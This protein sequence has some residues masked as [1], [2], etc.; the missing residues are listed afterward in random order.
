MLGLVV[1]H[2]VQSRHGLLDL[3]HVVTPLVPLSDRT[4]AEAVC[5]G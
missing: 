2:V 1:V 4:P 3:V 5:L